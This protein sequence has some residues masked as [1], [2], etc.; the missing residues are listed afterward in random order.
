MQWRVIACSWTLHLWNVPDWAVI[1][2]SIEADRSSF[3][4]SG[5]IAYAQQHAPQTGKKSLPGSGGRLSISHRD[6]EGVL[7]DNTRIFK[8]LH[9]SMP[10][11]KHQP[12]TARIS[13]STSE[14]AMSLPLATSSCTRLSAAAI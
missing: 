2:L 13:G 11:T 6:S 14:E 10:S 12:F 8:G 1:L 4:T 9:L 3:R 5:P 7:P